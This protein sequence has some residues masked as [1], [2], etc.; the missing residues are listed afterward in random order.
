[1]GSRVPQSELGIKAM[2]TIFIEIS[3]DGRHSFFDRKAWE[4]HPEDGVWTSPSPVPFGTYAWIRNLEEPY[5]GGFLLERKV[6]NYDRR[7]ELWEDLNN[8]ST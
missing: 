6:W 1:M 2:S 5:T 7:L 4:A 3:S 8:D